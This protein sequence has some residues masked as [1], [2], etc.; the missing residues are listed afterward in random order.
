[1][2]NNKK[3]KIHTPIVLMLLTD[4]D[5]YEH[6]IYITDISRLLAGTLSKHAH[7]TFTCLNCMSVSYD[8]QEK[9]DTHMRCCD[10]NEMTQLVMPK[11]GSLL[12]L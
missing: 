12:N 10:E 8:S 2:Y 7:K 9:L 3:A 6:F 1:M 4:T 11:E 5:G